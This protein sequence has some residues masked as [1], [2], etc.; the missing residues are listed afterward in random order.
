MQAT[1]NLTRPTWRDA[2][3]VNPTYA[4]DKQAGHARGWWYALV[5]SLKPIGSLPKMFS[6]CKYFLAYFFPFSGS[7]YTGRA[8]HVV[9]KRGRYPQRYCRPRIKVGLLPNSHTEVS[10]ICLPPVCI[11]LN[12]VVHAFRG[13]LW[14]GAFERGLI[15][16]ESNKC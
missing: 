6:P 8:V 13:G 10:N 14:A 12:N 15:T 1:Y 4:S 16:R 3:R 7:V 2:W 9:S 5:S 11:L